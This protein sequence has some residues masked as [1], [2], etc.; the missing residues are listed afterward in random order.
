MDIDWQVFSKKSK[1]WMK[2][3]NENIKGAGS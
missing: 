3:W 2:Y 1:E